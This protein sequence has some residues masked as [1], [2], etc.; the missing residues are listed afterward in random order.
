MCTK[1]YCNL[2]KTYIDN[3]NNT[4]AH[5][6]SY[7]HVVSYVEYAK[8]YDVEKYKML[9]NLITF[10]EKNFYVIQK[11]IIFI[12]EIDREFNQKIDTIVLD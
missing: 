10:N 5:L 11:S 12:E 7:V 8:L 2:C 6:E 3:M 1:Y 9:Q 4:V